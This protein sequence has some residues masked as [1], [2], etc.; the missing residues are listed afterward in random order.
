MTKIPFGI[1]YVKDVELTQVNLGAGVPHSN[2]LT[3]NQNEEVARHG[4]VTCKH[5]GKSTSKPRE[6]QQFENKKFHY[7]LSL[8]HISEPTRPY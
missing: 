2:H 5:C 3:I 8:I 7:G 6:V 4:F 1:E